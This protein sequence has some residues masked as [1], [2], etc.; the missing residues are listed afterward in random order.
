MP[1]NIVEFGA[2]IAATEDGSPW[3]V[4]SAYR[5]VDNSVLITWMDARNQHAHVA[6]ASK[7]R[8]EFDG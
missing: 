1:V 8:V 2:Y 6:A 3:C 5:A 4:R 7:S